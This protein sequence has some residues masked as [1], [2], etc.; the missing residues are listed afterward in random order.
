MKVE[1][2]IQFDESSSVVDGALSGLSLGVKDL[3]H[4]TGTLPK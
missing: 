4:I 3:F 1:W 2:V